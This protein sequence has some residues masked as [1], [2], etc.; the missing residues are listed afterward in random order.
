MT[1]VVFLSIVWNFFASPTGK[2]H[3]ILTS[4]MEDSPTVELMA[5]LIGASLWLVLCVFGV[6]TARKELPWSGVLLRG[7]GL[8]AATLGGGKLLVVVLPSG[9]VFSQRLA[10]SLMM[11]VVMVGCSMAA[12]T[13]RHIGLH[14]I[15]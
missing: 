3:S 12:Y 5:V 7:L 15:Q 1:G 2:I 4:F 10:L 11:W 6:R 13:R 9:L 8:G 14:A